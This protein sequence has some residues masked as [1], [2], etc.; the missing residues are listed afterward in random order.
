MAFQLKK[1]DDLE[2]LMIGRSAP[3]AH[4]GLGRIG[5]L[6]KVLGNPQDFPA[7]H[8]AG[9]NG[10][11]STSALL[12]ALYGA[13]GYT[14]GLYTS[15]HLVHMGERLMVNG[16]PV[17]YEHWS[18]AADCVETAILADTRLK[19]DRPTYFETFTATA[20]VLLKRLGVDLAVIETGLGGRLDAT[21]LLLDKRLA[22]IT[23]IGMDHMEFLG[24]TVELIAGEKFGIIPV[25]GKALFM[26]GQGNLDRQF[27][28][29][30]LDLKAQGHLMTDCQILVKNSDKY[31]NDFTLISPEGTGSYHVNL[32]GTFQ[33]RNAALALRA[34]E[35]LFD[36]FPLSTQ[37]K[38]KGVGDARWPGRMEYLSHDP[39]VMLDGAHNA[40][41]LTA[42]ASSL[43]SLY[44]DRP[45]TVLFA[46]MGD[47]NFAEGLKIL[48][49]EVR[50]SLVLTQVPDY[51][52]SATVRQLAAA[53]EGLR[54]IDQPR[55]L[56]DMV[57]AYR[58]ARREGRPLVV[59]GSLYF[60]GALRRVLMDEG[61]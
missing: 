52:R 12:S 4:P 22:V 26:G 25:G 21:N 49:D 19:E 46:A 41:G 31:G 2:E 47:K 32:V 57:Q 60:I 36:Q 48:T 20:F 11:G 28:T 7:I 13:G 15:P 44:G 40:H 18:A 34:T 53:A 23:P 56:P 61:V 51:P 10:K 39:D 42:L 37:A 58:L 5:Y 43:K 59:C 38:C 30:C 3:G 50:V 16:K 45:L 17:S 33:P 14:V 9:T 35:L 1:W 8:V 24:S 55:V 6:L 27:V 54:L 29:T